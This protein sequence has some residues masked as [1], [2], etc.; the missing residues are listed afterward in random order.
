MERRVSFLDSCCVKVE[1]EWLIRLIEKGNKNQYSLPGHFVG[2]LISEAEP[3]CSLQNHLHIE[4]AAVLCRFNE[5]VVSFPRNVVLH[6]Q[7]QQQSN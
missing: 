2:G 1:G 5:H 4:L 3:F 7:Q 6:R